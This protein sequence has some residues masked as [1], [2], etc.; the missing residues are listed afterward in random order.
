MRAVHWPRCAPIH[1]LPTGLPADRF[2]AGNGAAFRALCGIAPERPLLIYVGR[3]AHEKNI[4]FLIRM[5]RGVLARQPQAL[6]VIAGEGPARAALRAQVA[7]LGLSAHVHFA[8]HSQAD[9]LLLLDCWCAAD[10]FRVCPAHRDEQGCAAGAAAQGALAVP[11]RRVS[12]RARSR[13]PASGAVVVAEEEP[14][15]AAAV[16]RVLGDANLR[17]QLRGRGLSYARSWSS[18]AMARRLCEI[19]GGLTGGPRSPVD[20][21]RSERVLARRQHRGRAVLSYTSATA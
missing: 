15:F 12:T 8:G 7:A 6:L 11:D 17:A 10:V 5:F 9:M 20:F 3:V 2:R 18:A 13:M 4:G 14:A 19:Y 21:A 16:V 1:V